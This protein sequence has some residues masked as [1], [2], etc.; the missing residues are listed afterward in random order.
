MAKQGG[1]QYDSIGKDNLNPERNPSSK[2]LSVMQESFAHR[3]GLLTLGLR[4]SVLDYLA[5]NVPPRVWRAHKVC[6]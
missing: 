2:C 3:L 1:L 4:A 5:G 6:V